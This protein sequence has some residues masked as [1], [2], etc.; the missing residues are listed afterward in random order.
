MILIDSNRKT[1]IDFLRGIAMIGVIF[2]NFNS[3]LQQQL[4]PDMLAAT[5]SRIDSFL[6][7]FNSIFLEWK[8]MSL[9]SILFGFG[10]GVILTSVERAG[11][12]ATTFFMRR[13]A[14]LFLL[15][16]VH[17]LFWLGDVL[18]LYAIS[19]VLLLLFRNWNA[20]K[21]ML[22]GLLL[23]IGPSLVMALI[24]TF[25]TFS[26]NEQL[27]EDIYAGLVS[28]DMLKLFQ[29]NI[30]GYYDMY[31]ITGSEWQDITET[32]GRFLIGYWLLK[33]NA[34]ENLIASP[35]KIKRIANILFIPVVLY[36]I[37]RGLLLS[38]SNW[39][40][41]GTL[42]SPLLKTGILLNTFFYSS[43]ALLFYLKKKDNLLVRK[44]I[45]LGKMTLTNYLSVSAI[46]I[47]SLYGIGCSMLPVIK[48]HQLWLLATAWT[49]LLMWFSSQW[50]SYYR[51]GPAE[52]IWRQLSWMKRMPN[53]K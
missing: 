34:I 22:T 39:I 35:N 15:G 33:S 29:A 27:V 2:A 36:W 1:H 7:S 14:W 3:Y 38:E 5:A 46:L 32:L 6:M 42:L 45:G 43:V 23:T 4:P 53:K 44:I 41:I 28:N 30:N 12:N 31:I 37:V 11:E 24:K 47:I 16:L 10:F 51:Y 13:M 25:Y 18:H 48:I 20:K 49:A 17:T 8:F 9:F 21:L 52:W 19:G 40:P 50:L 26:H